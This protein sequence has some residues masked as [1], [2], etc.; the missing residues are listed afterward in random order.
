MRKIKYI[1]KDFQD[2]SPEDG[3]FNPTLS[4]LWKNLKQHMEHEEQ[5]DMV[6]LENSLTAHE[7]EHLARKFE[8]TKV[9]TPTRSH[10][11]AP[12]RPPFDTAAGL[13]S[14]PLDKIRDIFRKFPHEKPKQP[15]PA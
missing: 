5:K 15:P 6:A 7:S 14:A 4:V 8:R 3:E 1:L 13:M 9:L 11:E 12:D 10:P 2:M